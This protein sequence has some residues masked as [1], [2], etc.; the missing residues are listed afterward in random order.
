MAAT[1][2]TS[3][4][5]N[6]HDLMGTNTG[7]WT[8][9]RSAESFTQDIAKTVHMPVTTHSVNQEISVPNMY[10]DTVARSIAG[11]TQGDNYS[12][13]VINPPGEVGFWCGGKC[14]VDGI[15]TTASTTDSSTGSVVFR[16]SEVWGGGLSVYSFQLVVDDANLDIE[17]PTAR[18]ASYLI[19][20]SL[21]GSPHD[22]A[23][24][25]VDVTVASPGVYPVDLSSA[26]GDTIGAA[27]TGSAA[28]SGVL[29]IGATYADPEEVSP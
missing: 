11:V 3:L 19:V 28:V 20:S 12:F 5:F 29:L 9:N 27:L 14:F 22:V 24:G 18:T 23:V 17:L 8:L 13:A 16:P 7:A 4:F 2:C 1:A 15:D 25:G 26:S 10:T 6:E 21:T